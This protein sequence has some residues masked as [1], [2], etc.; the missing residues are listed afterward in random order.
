MRNVC[1]FPT[2][3]VTIAE[4]INEADSSTCS[5]FFL[6]SFDFIANKVFKYKISSYEASNLIFD[7]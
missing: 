5:I 7:V 1:D 3:K 2:F 4:N 6:S